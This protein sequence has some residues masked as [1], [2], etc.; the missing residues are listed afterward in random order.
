MSLFTNR[1]EI[2]KQG[3]KYLF[4]GVMIYLIELGTFLV[5][6]FLES[7]LY[8][9]ANIA[10]K[11]F[12]AGCGFFLHK[13]IT[14]SWDQEHNTRSQLIKYIALLLFNLI[15]ASTMLYVS[16]EILNLNVFIMKLIIDIIVIALA[17]LISRRFVFG[18]KQV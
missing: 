1:S 8:L 5:L 17:F 14:F 16:V 18:A 7:E 9:F 2:A 15:L 13:H 4:V 6:T 10:A 3:V 11:V 12:A